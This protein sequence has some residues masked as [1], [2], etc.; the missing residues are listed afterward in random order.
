MKYKN[1]II[2]IS[3]VIFSYF[4]INETNA[5]YIDEINKKTE[6]H[7]ARP[8]CRVILDKEIFI[9]NY[10]QKSFYFSI[11]NFDEKNNISDTAMNYS[12]M[13]HI[14]QI[15]TP[16]NYKLYKIE[17]DNNKKNILLEYESNILKSKEPILMKIDEKYRYNY[18]LEIEYD[19]KSTKELDK[20]LKILLEVYS[21]QYISDKE[22]TK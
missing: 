21:E 13:F 20:D 16:L 18:I 12:I 10:I 14:S 9:S 5:L 6:L 2:V 22:E 4:I 17:E 11:C 19:N 15:N 8:V 3:I 1:K 7:V